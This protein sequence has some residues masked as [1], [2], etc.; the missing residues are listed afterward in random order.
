MHRITESL[1]AI[2]GLEPQRLW[3]Y[4][5]EISCIP[6]ESG[7][8]A[9]VRVYL[10]DFAKKNGFESH[11][12]A[13]GNVILRAK[14]TKGYE[15]K[16]SVALQG[17][18][19][20]VCVKA[21]GV[22][23]DFQKDPLT[24]RRD[25]D[26]LCAVGTTLGA[27]NGIAIALILDLFT[28]PAAQHGPLEAIFTVAEETGLNGAFGLDPS[29]IHS[30]KMLNLD[31]EEEGVF[32]IGCA[33]GNE[34][35]ATLVVDEEP[36]PDDYI[37]MDLLVDGLQGGHSG[38]DVDQQRANSIVCTMRY[39][40]AL[41]KQ[42]TVMIAKIDGGTK[43]NVIPS[44]CKTTILLPAQDQQKAISLV[45][46]IMEDLRSEYSVS[47][48]DVRIS[49][50]PKEKS[51]ELAP[52]REQSRKLIDAVFITPNG[53]DRMSMTIEDLVETSSNLAVITLKDNTFSVIT[54]HRSS[55]LSSRDN[56]ADRAQTAL[57][58][59]GAATQI[60]NAYPAW[61][62]DISS[63]L[64]KFCADAWKSHTGSQ[65]KITAIH[66]GLEC[67]IINSLV[68]GMDS[69][70]LG[71]DLNGVHSTDEVLSIGSTARIAGFLRH[72]LTCIQ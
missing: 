60:V 23:H 25:G 38:A 11:T 47:D 55:V 56:I 17:H 5:F 20:M 31:S 2:E 52:S 6:R 41:N 29:Q 63:P 49:L 10:L 70:S 40:H 50:T 48:P 57:A 15:G 8:E 64:A 33:G 34:V 28:D 27:D 24:L 53:V 67:G 9:G 22:E 14:A 26:N 69:V 4:F 39:L 62:P 66:A 42:S 46:R 32:Y 18:M 54:S 71:P 51:F 35:D 72:L 1:K 3:H 30:R 59:C 36:V 37:Q 16:P 65:A 12:D 13:V 44:V 43:R 45:Q 21:E 7:N 58:S 61:T 68:P 19:D